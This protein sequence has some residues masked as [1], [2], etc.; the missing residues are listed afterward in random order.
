MWKA[1]EELTATLASHISRRM[2]DPMIGG[3][4]HDMDSFIFCGE[5]VLP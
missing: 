1:T 3:R 5:L 4:I 2:L